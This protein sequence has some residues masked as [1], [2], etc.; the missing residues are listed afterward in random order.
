MGVLTCPL[1][2]GVFVGAW[3][4]AGGPTIGVG[5]PGAGGSPPTRAVGEADVVV[6]TTEGAAAA[7]GTAEGVVSLAVVGR[8]VAVGRTALGSIG[9]SS[10]AGKTSRLIAPPSASRLAALATAGFSGASGT[11]AA[12]QML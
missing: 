6:A 11:S 7:T 4:P 1:G 2:P 10:A 5:W 8:G 12:S 9:G 3:M